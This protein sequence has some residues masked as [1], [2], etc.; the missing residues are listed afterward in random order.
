MWAIG[1]RY[2]SSDAVCGWRTFVYL[3]LH[4]QIEYTKH[5]KRKRYNMLLLSMKIVHYEPKSHRIHHSS[6]LLT[7][8]EIV[9]PL[10]IFNFLFIKIPHRL[11]SINWRC[12]FSYL[13]SLKKILVKSL[14]ILNNSSSFWFTP[15]T[16]QP[17]SLR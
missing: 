4:L 11:S 14:I 15:F 10:F 9:Y 16:H 3:V 8:P 13:L 6:S 17:C 12:W 2:R 5:H 7:S 1:K